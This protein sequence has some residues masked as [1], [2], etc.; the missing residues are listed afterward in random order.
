MK[1]ILFCI[2]D[3]GKPY[4]EEIDLPIDRYTEIYAWGLDFWRA[5]LAKPKFLRWIAKL[6]MGK[7]AYRELYGLKEALLKRNEL[8]GADWAV[9][10]TCEY[11]KDKVS[12][13]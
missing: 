12:L 10:E 11:Y 2:L 7:Y 13:D 4:I 3:D 8:V 1:G 9:S 6:A 5:F